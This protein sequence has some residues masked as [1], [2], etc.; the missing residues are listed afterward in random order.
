MINLSFLQNLPE[1]LRKQA[2]VTFE[3]HK[4]KAT[5]SAAYKK[6][7][8]FLLS[9]STQRQ[10]QPTKAAEPSKIEQFYRMPDPSMEQIIPAVN[11][12]LTQLQELPETGGGLTSKQINALNKMVPLLKTSP[13]PDL[14]RS[15]Q[16]NSVIGRARKVLNAVKAL[17]TA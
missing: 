13:D 8:T 7:R 11:E 12:M 2:N 15:F 17:G 14:K 16:T 1:L 6:Y 10:Q 5:Y 3:P 9:S 4:N